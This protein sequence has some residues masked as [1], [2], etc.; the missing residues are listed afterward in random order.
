MKRRRKP[1]PLERGERATYLGAE[2]TVV[3]W[4]NKPPDDPR[5][6]ALLHIPSAP[7]GQRYVIANA[8][9]VERA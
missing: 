8:A 1:K 2:A 6:V 4:D 9:L 5:P 3:L 7:L